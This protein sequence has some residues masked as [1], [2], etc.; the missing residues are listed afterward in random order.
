MPFLK[1]TGNPASLSSRPQL[2][3]SHL[4][5]RYRGPQKPSIVDLLMTPPSA[6]SEPVEFLSQSLLLY[7]RPS[8][9]LWLLLS[10]LCKA[11]TA[12]YRFSALWDLTKAPYLHEKQRLV[13]L[14]FVTI[15]IM[16]CAPLPQPHGV[17][18]GPYSRKRENTSP[19]AHMFLKRDKERAP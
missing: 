5:P 9:L 14:V 13:T 6:T 8:C 7:L 4:N 18:C 10:T 16:K 2:R 15:T 1:I 17:K 12:A 3:Q 19:P 11:S